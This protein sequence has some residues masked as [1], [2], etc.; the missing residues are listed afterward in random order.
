MFK[1][2]LCSRYLRS[3][4]IAL[5]SI[6]SVTLGVATMIVVN[7]VMSGFQ[8]EMY[9]RLH[10]ILSDIVVESHGSNGIEDVTSLENNIR[11][12]LGDDLEGLTTTVHI[13]SMLTFQ[14]RGQW[15]TKQVNL[16]GIDDQ[17][18]A[19]VSEFSQYLL[20]PQNRKHLSFMLREGG[21]DKRLRDAGRQYRRMRVAAERYQEEQ[22]KQMEL[23]TTD[24]ALNDTLVQ[25]ELAEVQTAIVPSETDRNVADQDRAN[26]LL[27]GEDFDLDLAMEGGLSL[28]DI[29]APDDPF[30]QL[31]DAPQHVFDP[32]KEEWTG[33][34]LG[35]SISNIRHRTPEG[36][37]ADFFLCRPG[38][39]V[40][41]GF[42]TAGKKPEIAFAD[43][44]V[45]DFYESK[46]SEYD[47]GF[48]FVPIRR[49]QEL[50]NMID[51]ATGEGAVS[52]IQLKLAEGANLELACQ[53][54]RQ[55]YPA[56]LF[57]YRIQTWK[58]MQ[59]PLL[60]A[61]QMETTILNILLFM[62]IAVAGFGI[63]ATF[64][65]I[66][67]EK[68]K[69]IGILKSLGA[70][71]KGVMSIFL[72]YGLSLGCVGSG[73]GM[74]LGLLFVVNINSIASLLESFTGREVFD[75]TIYYFQQ[76]P[77]IIEPWTIGWIV[78]GAMLIAVMA[79]VLPALR[80]ARMHP[81]EALRYE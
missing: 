50:R 62:I 70:S 19:S 31:D 16:I 14:V 76:I 74:V 56:E 39:D 6:I 25:E 24:A 8:E 48:A 77:T 17:T 10:G 67:V 52:S 33:I 65:M 49:L 35:I 13:P 64:F 27:A 23:Q 36:E 2:L 4:Y 72:G 11:D 34:I 42:P 55:H 9:K 5:A 32:A 43:F 51:P 21:Y 59:G 80:A 57:P 60:A 40:K 47:S 66:V 58:E 68:T 18:Y 22:R 20:H 61:V 26:E 46:M 37:V 1:L 53:K 78:L 15:I 44:T 69:D 30:A 73:V 12:I 54:L 7:S 28:D 79:S 63:L 3:R 41:V 29:N 71:K 38:D 45:V 75:P 81:V